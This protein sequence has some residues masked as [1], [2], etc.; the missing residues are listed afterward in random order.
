MLA[1]QVG[2]R[3]LLALLFTVAGLIPS[4]LFTQ[5]PAAS[6]PPNLLNPRCAFAFLLQRWQAYTPS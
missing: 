6:C 4:D 5:P 1:H 3:A 2:T